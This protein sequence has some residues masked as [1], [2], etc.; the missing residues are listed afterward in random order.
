M[1]LH[2]SF[3]LRVLI[4]TL[5]LTGVTAATAA[6]QEPAPEPQTHAALFPRFDFMMS[7][8]LLGHEDDRFNWDAHWAGDLDV[9]D[10]VRGRVITV[11]DY[12]TILGSEFRPFDPYQSNYLLEVMGTAR[13]GHGIEIGGVLNHVS[14]HLGDRFKRTPVAENSL[15]VRVWK[16]VVIDDQTQLAL[17]F[18]ARQVVSR[19]YVD[20]EWMSDLDVMLRR[21]MHPRA[22]L[23]GRLIGHAIGVDPAIAARNTQTGGRAEFGVT[24]RGDK[25]SVEFFGGL[26]RM[27]DADPLDRQSQQWPFF[28]FRLRSR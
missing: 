23:Y 3:T 4:C 25:G 22:Q 8:A 19:A 5:L 15:G 2:P 14:R 18:D 17:R 9:V 10:Y 11:L 1:I 12:Q 16:N 13:V 20:Y 24:I 28:G 27:I 6:A 21:T 7:A 26:E